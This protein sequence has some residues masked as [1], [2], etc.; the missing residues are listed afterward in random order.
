MKRE[1]EREM[2]RGVN[3]EPV[4]LAP[5]TQLILACGEARDDLRTTVC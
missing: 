2:E 3:P 5:Y 4:L 1:R